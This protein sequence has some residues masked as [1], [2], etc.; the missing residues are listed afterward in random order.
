LNAL[1]CDSCHTFISARIIPTRYAAADRGRSEDEARTTECRFESAGPSPSSHPATQPEVSAPRNSPM[2]SKTARQLPPIAATT[3]GRA[4]RQLA[5]ACAPG[6]RSA[7]KR[8]SL[9]R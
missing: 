8:A 1:D 3:P 7:S 6:P 4:Y 9:A 2:L 5:P